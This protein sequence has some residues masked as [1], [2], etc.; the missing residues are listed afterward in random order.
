MNPFVEAGIQ[1]TKHAILRTFS[2]FC[3]IGF[4]GIVSFFVYRGLN[5]KPTQSY[6][7]K[8]ENITNTEI[9]NYEECDKQFF[10]G[11][12]LFGLRLGVSK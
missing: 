7:Q 4:L 2:V 8:A 11:I 5:P 6:A 1:A 10:L 3:V 9:Y 12:K